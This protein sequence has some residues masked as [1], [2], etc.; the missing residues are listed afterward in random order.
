MKKVVNEKCRQCSMCSEVTQTIT[1][2]PI[3]PTYHQCLADA[4]GECLGGEPMNTKEFEYWNTDPVGVKHFQKNLLGAKAELEE[5][6]ERAG[7]YDD[8]EAIVCIYVSDSAGQYAMREFTTMVTDI[9]DEDYDIK[10]DREGRTKYEEEVC[11]FDEL[12]EKVNEELEL[13]LK[14][15]GL[16]KELEGFSVQVQW[17]D[18]HIVS[19]MYPQS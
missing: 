7:V 1:G 16:D 12:L 4:E 13:Y 19:M 18:G 8:M 15:T 17:W 3:E 14:E 11:D 2:A 9:T 10:Y 5:K 6:L